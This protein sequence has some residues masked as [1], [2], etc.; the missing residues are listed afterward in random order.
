MA[1]R[2]ARHQRF[3]LRATLRPCAFSQILAFD[4]QDVIEAHEG[5]VFGEHL[6]RHGLAPEPLLQRIEAGRPAFL[7]AL[8]AAAHEQFAVEHRVE[9]QHVEQFGEGRGNIVARARV[10]P[11][12]AAGTHEL[13]ADAVPFPL[14]CVIGEVDHRVL[15]RVGEHEGAEGRQVLGIG[16]GFAMRSPVEQ[17][18]VGRLEPMPVLLDLV[19]RHVESLREGGLR[20]AA[21]YADAHPAGRQFEQRI[22]TRGIEPV[23]QPGKF[24]HHA[25][26]C[27]GREQVDRFADTWRRGRI[28]GGGPQQA[29]RLRRVANEIAAQRPQHRID[30]LLHQIADRRAFDSRKVQPVGQRCQCPAAVGIGGGTQKLRDEPQFLVAGAR[31]DQRIDQGGEFFHA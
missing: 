27:H 3:E 26:A 4:D 23:E 17:F 15:E 21:R 20:Q 30:P 16:R 8:N 2:Q 12:L 28:G 10:E 18:G 25:L 7:T 19:D 24:R 5:R 9:R 13:H 22:A 11:R 6:L 14:R 1:V 29:R 31:V